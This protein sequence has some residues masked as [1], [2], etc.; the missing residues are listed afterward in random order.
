[1]DLYLSK[2]DFYMES[3]SIYSLTG[4]VGLSRQHSRQNGA[5]DIKPASRNLLI[6]L[7]W[8]LDRCRE[9]ANHSP[10]PHQEFLV[11]H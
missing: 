9:R 7:M 8:H 5:V 10:R 2:D 4:I 3:G 1:M 6:L 11:E